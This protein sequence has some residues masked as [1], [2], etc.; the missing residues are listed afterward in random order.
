MASSIAFIPWEAFRKDYD[1]DKAKWELYHVEQDFSQATDLAQKYP[2]KL[3][4]LKDLWWA[5][6]AREKV[7][8]LDWR[9]IERL[10]DQITGRPSLTEGRKTFVYDTPLVA[11]PEASAPD[12][13]NKSFSIT[14]EAEMPAQGGDGMIF[15]QGGREIPQR[16]HIIPG[17][18]RQLQAVASMI[19]HF[20]A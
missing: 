4:A 1:P 20:T 10:S 6:A 7:L 18:A 2:E 17:I 9:S 15:T 5:E 13:K 8:P 16:K 3:Q 19:E 14:A 12:L 11:L